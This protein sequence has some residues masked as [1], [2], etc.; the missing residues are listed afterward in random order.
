MVTVNSLLMTTSFPVRTNIRSQNPGAALIAYLTTRANKKEGLVF[1]EGFSG[2]GIRADSD[3]A[4]QI[5]GWIA[6]AGRH[7]DEKAC[8]QHGSGLIHSGTFSI[9]IW[10]VISDRLKTPPENR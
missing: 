1:E 2:G 5:G 3:L 10:S 7:R 8:G 4:C 6:G 9:M